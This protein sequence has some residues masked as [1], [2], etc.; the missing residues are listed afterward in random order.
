MPL[1]YDT[2][3]GH[4]VL[5]LRCFLFLLPYSIYFHALIMHYHAYIDMKGVLQQEY[6]Q[7]SILPLVLPVGNKT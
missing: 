2:D 1:G 7:P 4:R 3:Q 6:F 5:P